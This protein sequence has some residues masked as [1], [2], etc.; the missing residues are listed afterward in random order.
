METQEI[1]LKS[2]HPNKY[3]PNAMQDSTLEHLKRSI[4]RDGF[5][6]PIVLR[7]DPENTGQ[8]LIIDGEH[9]H[10]V[11]GELGQKT[12]SALVIDVSE[13]DAMVLTINLN[14]IRGV[15][16]ATRIAEIV[17]D[18][19]ERFTPDE[20]EDYLGYDAEELQ[21]FSEL[22]DLQEN[23]IQNFSN[24]ETGEDTEAENLLAELD[25][26][27]QGIDQ[28]TETFSIAVSKAQK[29]S[30][31][32][33]LAGTENPDKGEALSN[34]CRKFL[35]DNYPEK[36]EALEQRFQAAREKVN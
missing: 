3:N 27:Q 1:E 7:E 14:R 16:S 36:L 22:L 17:Q 9:R 28:K 13:D 34:I 12:I 10:K 23:D 5:L 18:L 6:Q 21:S 35:Q 33:V 26:E 29:E 15:M 25:N 30:I 2:I 20:L 31:E 8:Y 19:G 32:G 11:M 24:T 4:E